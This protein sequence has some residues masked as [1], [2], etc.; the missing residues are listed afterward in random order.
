VNAQAPDKL[1]YLSDSGSPQQLTSPS[2][3]VVAN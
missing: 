2:A 3:R 1:L